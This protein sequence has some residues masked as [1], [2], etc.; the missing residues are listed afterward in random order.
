MLKIVEDA[1]GK[2]FEPGNI[3]YLSFDEFREVEIRKVMR[4]IQHING[5]TGATY[6]AF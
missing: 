6:R 4:D 1:I 3:I 2:G 5:R